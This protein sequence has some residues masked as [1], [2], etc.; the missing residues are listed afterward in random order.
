MNKNEILKFLEENRYAD[1]F[2]LL[3]N[4]GANKLSYY[5]DL[6]NKFISDNIDH[7]FNDQCKV[8]VS[9]FLKQ[10]NTSLKVDLPNIEYDRNQFRKIDEIL[11]E[12]N[13]HEILA[14]M[15]KQKIFNTY[16]P[17]LCKFIDFGSY[18][19]NQFLNKKLNDAF[20]SLHSLIKE[21]TGFLSTIFY[22][23][24]KLDHFDYTRDTTVFIFGR[25]NAE[26]SY[27][28]EKEEQNK[29]HQLTD[30]IEEVYKIFRITVKS[31][32]HI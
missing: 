15:Q 10:D 22:N 23:E 27:K 9:T 2:E 1:F 17:I 8:F 12:E 20:I 13:L 5:N 19:K 26:E 7:H 16:D 25:Y 32:L 31:E 6:K 14:H 21:Y 30:D 24:E 11:S 29:L 3:D 18:V 28:K 4:L